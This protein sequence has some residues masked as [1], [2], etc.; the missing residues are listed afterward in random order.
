MDSKIL[1][2]LFNLIVGSA[3]IGVLIIIWAIIISMV[4]M[5]FEK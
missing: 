5:F 2:F 4:A 3:M 1:E